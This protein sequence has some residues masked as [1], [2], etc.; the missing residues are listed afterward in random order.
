MTISPCYLLD[1]NVLIAR[2]FEVHTHHRLAT[3]WFNAPDRKWALSPIAE[4][5]FMRY[6][7][8]HRK[9]MGNISMSEATAVLEKLTQHPGYQFHPLTQDWRTLTKPFFKRLQGHKQIM[10]AYLLGH[11]ILENLVLVT[12]DQAFLH[13]AGEHS[14]HVH[15]LKRA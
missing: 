10:D 14:K 8:D 6:S 3:Q 12:F 5:A 13:L 2:V 7:T 9:G 11:A 1:A 4:A 15:I